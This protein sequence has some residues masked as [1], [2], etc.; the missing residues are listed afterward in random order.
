ML[1]IYVDRVES[2]PFSLGGYRSPVGTKHRRLRYVKW[3]PEEADLF[4]AEYRIAYDVTF[5][6]LKSQRKQIC[7]DFYIRV[8]STKYTGNRRTP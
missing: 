5:C 2:T 8:N 1:D 6:L 7:W 4:E 3:I